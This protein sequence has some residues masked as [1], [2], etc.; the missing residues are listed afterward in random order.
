MSVMRKVLDKVWLKREFGGFLP[1]STFTP[2]L[3]KHKKGGDMIE[4]FE[5][6]KI[7]TKASKYKA[8]YL[9]SLQNLGALKMFGSS[10]ENWITSMISANCM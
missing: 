7:L 2:K 1:Q 9:G 5:I 10:C 4:S 8:Q 3:N 6:F